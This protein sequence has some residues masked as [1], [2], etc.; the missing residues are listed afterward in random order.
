MFDLD[1]YRE[2]IC[3]MYTDRKMTVGEIS[4]ELKIC[5]PATIS[6]YLKKIGVLRTRE[7]QLE[8][9]HK[10]LK[11][12]TLTEETKRHVSEGVKRSYRNVELRKKRSEDN[13]RVWSGMSEEEKKAR[14]MKGLRQMQINAQKINV[15]S[16]EI[17]VKEQLDHIGIRYIHQKSVKDGKFIVDFY[18]PSLRL[19]IECNGDY[20]HRL[21]ER[22]ERDKELKRYVE[23]TNRKII[24]IWEHEIRDDWFW[25][26]D[27]LIVDGGDL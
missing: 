23:S 16:I 6:R 2:I 10:V 13:K 24:F 22:V 12:R 25:I 14:Y 26:G 17:K 18:I 11:G 15:S 7:Q 5:S 27:Y 4:K 21:P 19:V 9:L 3:S 8:D 20:W 1:E